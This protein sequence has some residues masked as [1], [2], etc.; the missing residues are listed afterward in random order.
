MTLEEF[1][2][3]VPRD[4]RG[5]ILAQVMAHFRERERVSRWVSQRVRETFDVPDILYKYVPS[6]SLEF[7]CPLTL[8]A[9]QPV[10]LNDVMEGN[11]STYQEGPKVDRDWWYEMLG[12]R[13]REIFG[14]DSLSPE[15][16][17]RRKRLYGDPRVSTIIRDYLS[18]YIGVV[19]FSADPLIP[20]MWAY[21]AQNSGFV[22]GYR[23][24]ALRSLGV[25]L[26]RVLYMELAPAF[27]PT[28]GGTIELNFVDEAR[29][30]AEP[31][32]KGTPIL[33]TYGLLTLEKDWRTLSD[34]LF[35]KGDSWKSEREIRLLVDQETTRA[36]GEVDANGHR[37]KV[38]D[39]A[40]DAIEEVYVGFNTTDSAV[41]RIR[42]TVNDCE[43]DRRWKLKR[44]DSHAY[45]MQV[46]ITSINNRR[47]TGKQG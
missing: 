9:T 15:E 34:L 30:K 26:R 37:V 42:E 45:R 21:Y 22:V 38:L 19:S 44:T 43:S 23:T 29:R 33:D 47:G 39:V 11:I 13:L 17:E 14:E 41:R 12:E 6:G 24:E 25:G 16:L 27:C 32:R 5:Q 18:R 10:A 2:P 3:T 46:T 35:V 31:D 8:R 36:T 28:R 40:P 4:R 7:G 20:T 1:L